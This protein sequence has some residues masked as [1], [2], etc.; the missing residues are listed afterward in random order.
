MCACACA[1]DHASCAYSVQSNNFGACIMFFCMMLVE[2]KHEL[3]DIQVP[4]EKL[5]VESHS[6]WEEAAVEQGNSH[7]MIYYSVDAGHCGILAIHID[8]LSEEGELDHQVQP[9]LMTNLG[10]YIIS[11]CHEFTNTKL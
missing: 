4:V 10:N 11:L 6:Q 7:W 3:Q 5:S 2:D 1:V 8:Q 9:V